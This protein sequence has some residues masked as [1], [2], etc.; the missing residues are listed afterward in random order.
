MAT[1]TEHIIVPDIKEEH[2][3]QIKNTNYYCIYLTHMLSYVNKLNLE[4]FF[5]FLL[6]EK[7][8]VWLIWLRR[9]FKKIWYHCGEFSSNTVQHTDK[10]FL[11]DNCICLQDN[12]KGSYP[13][14]PIR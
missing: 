13:M 12:E 9:V 4:M 11:Q 14:G 8:G 7:M 3:I 5:N 10:K 6:L 2:C 1:E